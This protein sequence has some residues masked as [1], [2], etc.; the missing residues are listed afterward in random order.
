MSIMLTLMFQKI[1]VNRTHRKKDKETSMH[2]VRQAQKKT[3]KE[4][5]K[6]NGP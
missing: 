6:F 3:R 1:I 4:V 5:P 2:T